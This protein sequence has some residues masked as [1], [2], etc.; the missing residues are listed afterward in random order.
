MLIIV[1]ILFILIENRNRRRVPTVDSIDDISYG[2]AFLIGVFQMIAAVFPGTSRSGSNHHGISAFG[3]FPYHGWREF[4]F[5]LA[6]PAMLG[7]S[8]IKVVKV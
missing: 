3:Y 1:G 4:T 8:A 7:G 6:I 5:F 2:K